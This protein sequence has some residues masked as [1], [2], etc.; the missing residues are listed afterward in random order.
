MELMGLDYG[1]RDYVLNSREPAAPT[2]LMIK[3]T[4][5][6]LQTFQ[7]NLNIKNYKLLSIYM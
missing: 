6:L 1:F 5:F 4:N 7:R 3:T 2:V